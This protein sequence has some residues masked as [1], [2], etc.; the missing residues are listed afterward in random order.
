MLGHGRHTPPDPPIQAAPQEPTAMAHTTLITAPELL[1]LADGPA[2]L[3]LLDC[4]FDLAD[5]AA[6]AALSRSPSAPRHR[7]ATRRGSSW[8][9]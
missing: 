2:T 3:V 7:A 4:G 5:P 8:S 9:T 1:A 6:P